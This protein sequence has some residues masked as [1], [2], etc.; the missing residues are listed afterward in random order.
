M[1]YAHF[2]LTEPPFRITPNTEVFFAG[3]NRGAILDAL[4]YAIS[5]GE[6][7]VKVT[8]EVGTG[9]TMLCSMLQSRLP[10]DIETI[11]LAHP[12]LSPEEILHAIAFELRLDVARD[13]GRMEVMQ[14]LYRYLLERHAQGKQVVIFIEESQNMPIA[15]LE[16]VRLL[17]NLETGKSK[18]LQI[19]LFGQ[20][21]LDENLRQPHIRQLRERIT[22]SF[23]LSPLTPQEIAEY[24]I[25]RLRAVGYRGPDLFSANVIKRIAQASAGLTRRVNLIA[26]KALLAAF[27]ENTH[28]V[29]VKHIAAAV[30]DS[31]FARD[32]ELGA[33]LRSRWLLIAASGL[34]VLALAGYAALRFFERAQTASSKPSGATPIPAAAAANSRVSPPEP[35]PARNS[36]LAA[37]HGT[38]STLADAEHSNERSAEPAR[39]PRTVGKMGQVLA[40]DATS[41]VAVVHAQQAGQL[42]VTSE[43]VSIPEPSGK[44][45]EIQG[46]VL[47]SRIQATREWLREEA[48]QT[49]SIQLLGTDNPQK[50]K[51]HL[52]VIAKSIE[53][54]DVFVYRTLAKQ[55]PFLSVLYG[56]FPS[57]EAAQEA[58][59]KLPPQLRAF[60]PY[61]RTAQGIREEMSRNNTL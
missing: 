45:T 59:D 40:P 34:L 56:R 25:F 10:S 5:Q 61:L 32:S 38:V 28:T 42:E 9:K 15:T 51:H 11:Y 55:K 1:Y 7:I 43:S 41:A 19:V 6:G 49:Y 18:L 47:A 46:D 3:G 16:E 31:E 36:A 20:P 2:G 48:A 58:L 44:T 8:G 13:A 4:I 24:L 52:N 53:I 35:S 50:L 17:S 27:A 37:A 12:S 54:N 39:D 23:T 33:Q 30:R 29:Q 60:K 14:A 22:H 57:R 21:E 26:D